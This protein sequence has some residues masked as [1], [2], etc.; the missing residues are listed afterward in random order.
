[1]VCDLDAQQVAHREWMAGVN[2]QLH[3]VRPRAVS[4]GRAGVPRNRRRSRT[5]MVHRL[6]GGLGSALGGAPPACAS[7]AGTGA[8]AD[9]RS[10][11]GARRVAGGVSATRGPPA[12][13]RSDVAA[14]SRTGVSPVRC[15]S[16]SPGWHPSRS[17]TNRSTASD[18]RPDRFGDPLRLGCACPLL[19]R[20]HLRLPPG[21]GVTQG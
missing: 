8:A 15:V 4:E 13:R 2:H 11:R 14:M 21:R 10:G 20:L 16:N 19:P 1:M 17:T 6:Q 9:R 12:G 18:H 5:V 7:M 3:S